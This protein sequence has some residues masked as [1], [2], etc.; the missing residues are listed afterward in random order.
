MKFDLEVAISAATNKAVRAKIES[1]PSDE[2]KAL[3]LDLID[4]GA[5]FGLAGP[6]GVEA[7]IE[8]QLLASLDD[9]P[10]TISVFAPSG[11]EVTLSHRFDSRLGNTCDIN[12]NR[13][14]VP[15]DGEGSTGK[16]IEH[17][18]STSESHPIGDGSV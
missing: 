5:I 9:T 12:I 16:D 15:H 1:M 6:L 8:Q 3:I 7:Q 11:S 10:V 14:P 2:V 4:K 13:L 17:H 18:R